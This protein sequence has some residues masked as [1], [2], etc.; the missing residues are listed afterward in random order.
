MVVGMIDAAD[1][2]GRQ[3]WN[4][5]WARGSGNF[6][7]R[8]VETSRTQTWIGSGELTQLSPATGHGKMDIDPAG[9]KYSV[10]FT[11]YIVVAYTNDGR[12]EL[13]RVKGRGDTLLVRTARA[14]CRRA[15]IIRVSAF[16][17][18]R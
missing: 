2:G 14:G 18:D 11:P 3:R 9:C 5:N 6:N 7:D 8:V 1:W 10:E 12:E 16:C 17:R 4:A 15:G 13:A